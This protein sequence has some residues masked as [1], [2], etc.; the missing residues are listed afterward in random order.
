MEQDKEQHELNQYVIQI[1]EEFDIPL[2]STV[3]C[4]Y[5]TPDSWKDSELYKRLGYLGRSN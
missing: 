5:P 1:A 4:H 3:D 2:I